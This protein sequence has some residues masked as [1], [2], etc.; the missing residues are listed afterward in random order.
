MDTILPK[1]NLAAHFNG[2]FGGRPTVANLPNRENSSH[3]DSV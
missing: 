2:A 3:S 1:P